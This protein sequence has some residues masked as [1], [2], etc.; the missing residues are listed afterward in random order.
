[1][2]RQQLE[3][4]IRAAAEITG[5][6][7]IVV[8]GSQAILGEHPDAPGDLLVSNEA[9]VYPRSRPELADLIDGAIGELSPFHERFG[10]YA[11]GVS[12]KTAVMPEGWEARVVQIVSGTAVG[13]CPETHDLILAK[14]VAGRE[15]DRDYVRGAARHGLVRQEMLMARL[16][17]LSITDD[18][19]ARLREL[20]RQDFAP[21]CPPVEE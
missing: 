10:Y 4:I 7:E 19:K 21:R 11:E 16:D 13:L 1:M 2:T 8:V 12:P 9:D 20:I 17:G 15:K 3:H 18:H 6:R 5:C 14:Y